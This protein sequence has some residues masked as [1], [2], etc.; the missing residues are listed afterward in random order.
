VNPVQLEAIKI[1]LDHQVG[2][3][4]Q[5]FFFF[6]PKLFYSIDCDAGYY[7]PSLGSSSCTACAKGSFS[8]SAG[9]SSW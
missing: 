1:K 5:N 9:S 7:S 4:L 3:N 6:K 8:A 2:K